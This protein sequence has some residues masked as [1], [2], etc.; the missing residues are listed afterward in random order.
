MHE[1]FK[2]CMLL[3]V[4]S[5]QVVGVLMYDVLCC[6]L[7]AAIRTLCIRMKK[8]NTREQSQTN[9]YTYIVCDAQISIYLNSAHVQAFNFNNWRI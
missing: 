6:V 1:N 5:L 9:N 4:G 2:I 7:Y 8:I 3:L